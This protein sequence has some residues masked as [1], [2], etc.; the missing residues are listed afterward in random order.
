MFPQSTLSRFVPRNL[1][2]KQFRLTLRYLFSSS[3]P[4]PQIVCEIYRVVGSWNGS[5]NKS[6][7]TWS[8]FGVQFLLDAGYLHTAAGATQALALNHSWF[9]GTHSSFA[10]RSESCQS[11]LPLR[12][13]F[14]MLAQ[15]SQLAA[16]DC[17]NKIFCNQSKF[18]LKMYVLFAALFVLLIEL[19][20]W[21]DNSSRFKCDRG[22]EKED[23][24]S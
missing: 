9:L 18:H 8:S 4:K 17:E 12:S 2:T 24:K 19:R 21:S 20:H 16:S 5:Y 22:C 14:Q 11:P 13:E 23:Y 3:A 10:P 1:S 6:S 15:K 7:I